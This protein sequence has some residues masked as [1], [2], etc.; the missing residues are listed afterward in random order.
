M[1]GSEPRPW[2]TSSMS[3]PTLSASSAY[4]VRGSGATDFKTGPS[5]NPS[6]GEYWF[7]R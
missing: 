3:A 6:E 1:R 2:R 4:I 5:P 7:E